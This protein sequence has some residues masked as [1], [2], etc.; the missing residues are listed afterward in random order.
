MVLTFSIVLFG[1]LAIMPPLQ[2]NPFYVLNSALVVGIA[3]LLE[4]YYFR[5]APFSHKTLLLLVVIQLVTINFTTFLAYFVDKRAAQRGAYRIPER[6][7]HTLEF[8][9]GT[10]GALLGQRLLHHKSKKKSY[11]FFFH[12]IVIIQIIAVFA[13]LKY[14]RFI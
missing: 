5:T 12:F 11:R 6:N 1:L 4:N 3:W 2:R 7:L 8:L 9:G 10:L 14:L 13:I